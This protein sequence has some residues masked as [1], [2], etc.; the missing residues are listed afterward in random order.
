MMIPNEAVDRACKF[1]YTLK[2]MDIIHNQSL[3]AFN[4]FGM[5]VK[6]ELFVSVTSQDQMAEATTDASRK[7]QPLFLLGGGSNV[8]LRSNVAGLTVHNAIQGIEVIHEN[9]ESAIVRAGGGV[10]WH[11]FVLWCIERGLGGVENMSLIPG[12][13]GAAPMQNIGAYGV[14]LKDVFHALEAIDIQTGEVHRFDNKTCEFGYRT[15]IFKTTVKGRFAITHVEFELRKKPVFNTSYGAIEA[16]LESM[17]VTELSC[18]AISDAVIAIRKSKLPDP[19]EIGNA[20]S[21][22]KNPVVKDEVFNEI[23][24]RYPNVPGYPAGEGLMKLPAGWLIEQ[25]GWKGKTFGTYGVHKKQALVLVNYGGASGEDVYRLST[26]ILE[27]IESK[28]GVK[29]EREVNIM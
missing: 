22:F 25:A 8:L 7:S 4:T 18:K 2:H 29:L 12:S 27:D 10:E 15:S 26:Q 28:F 23:K 20:G 17:G 21:F 6:A 24:H 16:E 1:A 9:T 13:V 19:K 14:E 5:D 11:L 3:L